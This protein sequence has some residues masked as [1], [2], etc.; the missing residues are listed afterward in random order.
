MQFS[1]IR[2]LVLKTIKEDGNKK[3]PPGIIVRKISNNHPYISKKQIFQTID[4]M[5]EKNELKSTFD[6]KVVLGYIDA[7]VDMSETFVGVININSNYDGFIAMTNEDN[8]IIEE[9]YVNKIHTNGSLKGDK[10]E[11]ALLKKEPSPQGLREASVVKILEHKKSIIVA[12]VVF[13]NDTYSIIPD[14]PKFYLDIEVNNLY[15]IESHDKV[16]LKI[17]KFFKDKV[18]ASV[19]RIIGNKN[20]LGVDIESITFENN[21]PVDFSEKVLLESENLKFNITEKDKQLR[22]DI[23]NRKIISIDP[24]TSKD[25]DDA[26][27]LEKR[28][29]GNF[30]LSVSIADV[31]SY[32]KPNTELNNVALERGTS[33]YLVNKV[34]P[35]LPHNISDNLCSL[36]QDEDKMALTCDVIISPTGDIE[37]IDVFPSIMRNH[38][39]LSY[40]EVNELFSNQIKSS[41]DYDIDVLNQLWIGHE[42]HTILRKKK[43]ELGYIEFD[44]KEPYIKLDEITGIPIEI[45]YKKSGTAQKMIEDFMV[46]CNEAVTLFAQQHNLPFI[47]RTHDRPEN[48]K[49]NLFL[50]ECKKMGFASN[51]DYLNLKSKD[52]LHLLELNKNHDQFKIFNKLLLKSMQKA[53]YT[54]QNIGHFGLAIENY[55]HFTSPIRRY[56]DLIIHRIFW[57][58]IFDRD[59]YSEADRIKLIEDLDEIAKQCNAS[60]IRQ[61]E[62]ERAVNSMKFAEYMSY[63]IGEEYDG[64]VSAVLSYGLF[65]ELDNMIEGLVSLKNMSDDFFVYNDQDLTLIG[66]ST[67]KIYT[68]GSKVKIKVISANKQERKID[69]KIVN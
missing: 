22:K 67:N 36:N 2:E 11:F 66:R 31:S 34:I 3:I 59:S 55:T 27:Y 62:T 39:R 21:V 19:L 17:E 50:T 33:V 16:V 14:D 32:V 49:I 18:I 44:I 37:S 63:R 60:E 20:N 57:M 48:K 23:R 46:I 15:G 45:G 47:Y 5:I 30:F 28:N 25:L 38:K 51:V 53:K 65:V 10:V 52:F 41:N 42:L 40:G 35:M 24:E 12:E 43:H 6:N 4:I 8:E 54:L 68:M 56:S 69:F 58:F 9:F 64:I 61:A 7:E 26:I 29:D 1:Q 13:D